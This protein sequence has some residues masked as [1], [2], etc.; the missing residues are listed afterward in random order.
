MTDLLNEAASTRTAIVDVGSNSVRLVIFGHGDR[1]PLPML[2]EKAFCALGLG[3]AET[4]KLNPNGVKQAFDTL[5]RFKWVIDACGVGRTVAFATAAVRDAEDGADFV[6]NVEA[7]TGI[8]LRVLSGE[9]EAEFAG[10]GVLFGIPGA[11]GVAADMGGSS[12]ELVPLSKGVVLPG[13]SLSL[14]PL[15][16]AAK[17][18]RQK[19]IVSAVDQALAELPW[20]SDLKGQTLYLVGGTWR[21]FAKLDIGMRNYPLNIIHGYQMTPARALDLASVVSRQSPNSLVSAHGISKRRIRALPVSA[22]VLGR[23]LK[24]LRPDQLIFSAHGVR[25]GA[26]FEG[27][28][29]NIADDDP[30]LAGVE[31]MA[32]QEA[33]FSPETG[34]EIAEWIAPLFPEQTAEQERIRLA[35]CMLCDVGWRAHPDYRATQSFRR[36]LRAP[37]IGLTHAERCF[38]AMALLRRYSHKAGDAARKQA[39]LVL[40]EADI[41]DAEKIGASIRLAL[42]LGGG[43]PGV[44]SEFNLERRA[45]ELILKCP[46]RSQF[47]ASEAV[48]SRLRHLATLFLSTS[49]IE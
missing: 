7:Q 39:S 14:G 49:S 16:F 38:L 17:D 44:L 41:S 18:I 26:Y 29:A 3:V 19:D 11:N 42:T 4:R 12:L 27:Q 13:A 37:L 31:E 6:A 5:K 23:L 21:A 34:R 47:I 24:V 48:I 43:A 40:S 46:T 30:L 9:K 25:E 32:I 45:D 28:D 22:I 15:Q 8:T 1:A 33:R 20:L 35:A 10:R 2:N 36:V